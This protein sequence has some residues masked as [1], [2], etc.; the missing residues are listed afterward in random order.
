MTIRIGAPTVKWS[1]ATE[2]IEK[3]KSLPKH[4]PKNKARQ[5]R[6]ASASIRGTFGKWAF[7]YCLNFIYSSP[8]TS[9]SYIYLIVTYLRRIGNTNLLKRLNMDKKI[10]AS[11]KTKTR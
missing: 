1:I 3:S 11:T 7:T 2:T 4:S 10:E 9:L 6:N 5:Q 8:D